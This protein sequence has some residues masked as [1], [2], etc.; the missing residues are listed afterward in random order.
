MN[1]RLPDGLPLASWLA[2]AAAALLCAG[3]LW[4]ALHLAPLPE[5]TTAPAT[6]TLALDSLMPEARPDHATPVELASDPFSVD[7]TLPDDTEP[8]TPAPP[9]TAAVPPNGELRLLGTVLRANGSFALCQLPTDV[10]RIV[11]VGEQ[12][13]ELTLI[14]LGQGRAIF[15][16]RDGKPVEL[17]LSRPGT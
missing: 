8:D 1:R 9:S 12:V 2:L 11:H 14:S 5:A 6:A 15:R 16:A 3:G 7:R 10:P 13:G 17:S 4:S